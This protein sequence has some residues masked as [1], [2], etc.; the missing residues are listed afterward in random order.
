MQIA[1]CKLQNEYRRL[2]AS[3]NVRFAFCILQFAIPI[4]L[5]AQ[6]N[7]RATVT[8][9]RLDG[10]AVTGRLQRWT[11]EQI[12]L[13]TS[14]GPQTIAV[15]QLLSLRLSPPPAAREVEPPSAQLTDGLQ[16][17]IEDYLASGGAA[18]VQMSPGLM[19]KS[20]GRLPLDVKQ[21][22]AVRLAPL[23]AAVL[24][25]WQEI[26]DLNATADVLVVLKRDGASLDHV[27]GVLGDVTA[28]KIDFQLDGEPS[29][30]DRARAA[31]MIYFRRA[32]RPPADPR[33]MITGKSGLR[34]PVAEV[35]M[36]G[37]TLHLTTVSGFKLDWPLSDVILAD[38]SAGKLVYLSD[39]DPAAQT[40]TPL[41]ALPASAKGAA[42][43]GEPRRD[44]SPFGGSLSLLFPDDAIAGG[45]GREHIY[46]KGLSLRSR[47]R[48]DY[49]LPAGFR[50]LVT[51][52][53]IDPATAAVGNVS[54]LIQADDK[55]LLEKEIG[56]NGPPEPI[57]LNIAGARRLSIVVDYGRN[58][59]KGDWLNLCDA[60]I[61]K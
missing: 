26:H 3:F 29:R 27:E 51:V 53:G 47:T 9:T 30:I 39:L 13:A 58:L 14:T 55:V 35:T 50:R 15:E 49:R 48:L 38:F 7:D 42:A 44:M 23:S 11:N 43:Y 46:T 21:I 1:K 8:A 33:C 31:G 36:E 10:G 22:A 54:L 32:S 4:S 6:E 60:R 45:A 24:P 25:Q 12:T 56:G 19:P 40:W 16:L 2:W 61:V 17:P 20:A 5:V 57:D 34:A 18:A 52:A 37:E 28:G 41:V 59:D